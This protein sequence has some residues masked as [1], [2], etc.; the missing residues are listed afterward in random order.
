VLIEISTRHGHLSPDAHAYLHEK[1]EKLLRY[2]DRL[3]AIEVAVD[4]GKHSWEVEIR[5]SAEHKHDFFAKEEAPT[6]QAAMDACLHKVEHQLK[7]YKERVQ[8]HTG[9]LPQGGTTPDHPD[10]PEPPN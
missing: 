2:F 9:A 5:A 7:K 10:L 3:M 4:H 6:P 1:A 8:D